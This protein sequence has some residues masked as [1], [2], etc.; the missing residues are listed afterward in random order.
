VRRKVAAAVRNGLEPVLCVGEREP[1]AA[2][3]AVADC[4]AQLDSALAAA[5]P[6][7]GPLIVAYEPEWAIGR[8]DPAPSGHIAAVVEGVRA[9]LA[10]PRGW[11]GPA[12]LIY[13]GSA[14]AG[15]LSELGGA[16]DGLF[17]GRSAHD[18]GALASILDEAA[19][20]A[21]TTTRDG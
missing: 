21:G 10:G 16:V 2:S 3:A 15:Q 17:L 8:A 1:G 6:R 18:T 20:R 4:V 13:G 9:H 12:R 19:A 11:E 5:H 14:R 7:T